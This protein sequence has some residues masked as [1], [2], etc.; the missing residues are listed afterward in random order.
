MMRSGAARVSP[1]RLVH[2]PRPGA[3]PRD[4]P[5]LCIFLGGE[6][7]QARAQRVFVWSIERV[8]DPGRGYESHVMKEL[9]GFRTFGW[10]AGFTNYRFA[11]PHFAASLA[12]RAGGERRPSGLGRAIYNDV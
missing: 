3:P 12:Q 4:P 6:H 1:E 7:A 11:I 9:A 10:T 8:R 2:P 5:P